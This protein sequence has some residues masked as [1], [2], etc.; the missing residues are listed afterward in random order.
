MQ[1]GRAFALV[2]R[3][4]SEFPYD[5][6]AVVALHAHVTLQAENDDGQLLVVSKVRFEEDLPFRLERVETGGIGDRVAE[7]DDRGL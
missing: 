5:A 3:A 4:A 2:G 1:G 7:D 6:P